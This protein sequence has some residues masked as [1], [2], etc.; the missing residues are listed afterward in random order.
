MPISRRDLL[1][2]S[3]GMAATSGFTTFPGFT[4]AHAQDVTLRYKPEPGASLRI[5]RWSSFVKADEETWLA[6]TKKFSDLTGVPVRVDKESWEDIGPKAAVAASV[7]SGPDMIMVWLD[8]A[9]LY[10]DKLLDMTDLADYLSGKYGGWYPNLALYS[11]K[12]KKFIGLPLATIGNAICYRDSWVKQAGFSAFPK[13]TAGFLEVCKALKGIGHPA[14]FTLG[15]GVGDGNNFCY[16]VL[17]S[18]GGKVVDDAGKVVINSPE[19]IAALRYVRQLYPTFIP[20]TETW[21]DVNNNRAFLAGEISATANGILMYLASKND[22]QYASMKGDVKA[23]N[24]PVGPTGVPAEMFATSSI[25]GFKYTKYPN[26]LKAYL[27]FM[28]EAPQMNAWI[29]GSAGSYCQPLKAFA[30]NPIWT[31][32]PNMIPFSRASEILRPSGYSGP[33]GEASATVLADYIVVDMVAEA[34][35]GKATPEEAAKRAEERAKRYYRS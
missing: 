21:L 5:L 1:L 29:E 11:L 12:D 24:M 3:A 9:Q 32:D 26:A 20:G 28:F 13:D 18:H 17:W 22:S 34:A 7:G 2:A 23:V 8:N 15:H 14:G 31:S 6:N 10:A 25:V 33:L 27:Q 16:W 30:A 19:T 35:T 4:P